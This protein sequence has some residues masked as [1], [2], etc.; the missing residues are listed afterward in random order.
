MRYDERISKLTKKKRFLF[1]EVETSSD[2]LGNSPT[3]NGT[4]PHCE[5]LTKRTTLGRADAK[6]LH[7]KLKKYQ[8]GE[9]TDDVRLCIMCLRAIMNNQVEFLLF[10]ENKKIHQILH[11][12]WF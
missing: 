8:I 3:L 5:D 12:E 4:S 11:L 1:R 2:E 9:A 6:R 10:I 7:R